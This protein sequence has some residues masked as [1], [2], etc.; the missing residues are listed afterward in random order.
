MKAKF[1]TGILAIV[2]LSGIGFFFFRHPNF[3]HQRPPAPGAYIPKKQLADVGYGTPEAAFETAMWALMSDNYERTTGSLDP[4]TQA[5]FKKNI[6]REHFEANFRKGTT[7][8]KGIQILAKQIIADDKVDL[9]ILINDTLINNPADKYRLQILVKISDEWKIDG[10][11]RRYEPS[12]D[13]GSNIVTFV[14]K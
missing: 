1:A 8:F 14:V 11:V 7:P 9:K 4:E 13:N 3:R 5:E 12:W 10:E 2:I 6:D